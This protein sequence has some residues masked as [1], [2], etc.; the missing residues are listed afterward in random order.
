MPAE[1]A[2]VTGEP[3]L[4]ADP[5]P[6]LAG[7]RAQSPVCRVVID[8]LPAWLITTHEQARTALADARLSVDPERASAAARAV[9]WVAAITSPGLARHLLRSDP[10][11]HTRLRRLVS[12][13]FTPRRVAAL[14]PRIEQIAED[15]IGDFLPRGHA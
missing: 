11:D 14:R 7:L 6:F 12:Q 15:L 3:A 2:M 9:P 13:A 8:G 10:P 5:Y 1:T 4:A